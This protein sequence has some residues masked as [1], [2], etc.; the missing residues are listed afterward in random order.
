MVPL[1]YAS[2]GQGAKVVGAEDGRICPQNRLWAWEG[3]PRHFACDEILG[4]EAQL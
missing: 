3:A 4:R 1:H 2:G